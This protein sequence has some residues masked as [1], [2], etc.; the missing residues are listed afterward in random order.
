MERLVAEAERRLPEDREGKEARLISVARADGRMESR[1]FWTNGK[2]DGALKRELETL[3]T[4]LEK[5]ELTQLLL[6]LTEKLMGQESEENDEE[7]DI[8]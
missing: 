1:I 7:V 8:N 4:K 3:E 5:A 2:R 6:M